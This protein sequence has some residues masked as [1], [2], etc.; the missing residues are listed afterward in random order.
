VKVD[1]LCSAAF[2]ALSTI[3]IS[4]WMMLVSALPGVA[5]D[6]MAVLLIA[7]D[8]PC[9]LL[10]DDVVNR[11][12]DPGLA[13]KVELEPGYR[14]LTA[15]SLHTTDVRWQESLEV[16]EDEQYELDIEIAFEVEAMLDPLLDTGPLFGQSRSRLED[17]M[18]G[19]LHDSETELL[20]TRLDNNF[21]IDW[22]SAERYCRSMMLGLDEQ[23]ERRWRLPTPEELEG[24]LDDHVLGDYSI[25]EGF[26]LSGCCPW[27]SEQYGSVSAWYVSFEDGRRGFVTRDYR[28][29]GRVLC[30]R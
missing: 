19:S 8:S 28:Q 9:A 21:D 6:G 10:V 27:T 14:T 20:W 7:T 26:R 22:D 29:G 12:L 23:P 2:W 4:L 18:D 30:V 1:R 24:L 13:V 16:D 5:A 15:I 3:L 17:L 25:L 11:R